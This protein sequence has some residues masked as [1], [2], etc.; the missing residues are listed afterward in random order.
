MKK[1]D[2]VKLLSLPVG[3]G[4]SRKMIGCEGEIT[5][6]VSY[7]PGTEFHQVRLDPLPRE[8]TIKT[9]SGVH[10]KLLEL[11]NE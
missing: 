8:R 9:I 10:P 5:H 4:L 7:M 11:I 3:S 2:R 1:G 6:T